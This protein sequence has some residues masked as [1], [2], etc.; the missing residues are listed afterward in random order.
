MNINVVLMTALVPTTGHRDLIEFAY[1]IPADKT[2]VIVSTRSFEPELMK[3]RVNDIKKEFPRN[4]YPS[5]TIIEHQ[6]DGAPQNPEDHPRFWDWWRDTIE[7]LTFGGRDIDCYQIIASEPYGA[8]VAKSLNGIFIPFDIERQLNDS[9]GSDVRKDLMYNWDKILLPTRQRLNWK[10]T[11]FGQESVGKTTITEDLV[12]RWFPDWYAT[13]T[14]EYARPYLETVGADL[15]QKKME[16]IFYGQMSMQDL[17]CKKA[18][19]P[20]TILD[21]DLYSTIG[22]FEIGG[23]SLPNH[24]IAEAQNRKSDVYFILPDDVPFEEDPLRY[25]GDKRES[26]MNFWIDLCHT[27]DLT[28]I[29]V[30]EGTLEEKEEFIS[31]K[32]KEYTWNNI[33]ELSRFKRD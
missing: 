2:V 24:M 15:T 33:K 18:E 25:G 31:N 1:N 16:T 3:L 32:I 30:P 7:K 27:H 10:F 13:S 29:I 6:C 28:Y 23:F 19:K 21:T 20:V 5:L 22:Y 8:E 12:N 11:L 14:P 9:R 26:T 4:E 17:V